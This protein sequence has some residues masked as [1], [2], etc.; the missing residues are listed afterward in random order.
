MP[1]CAGK[2]TYVK[3]L[4]MVYMADTLCRSCQ[5]LLADAIT[6]LTRFKCL[7]FYRLR[8]RS[9]QNSD[10]CQCRARSFASK[11]DVL[12]T[13]IKRQGFVEVSQLVRLPQPPHCFVV[14]ILVLSSPPCHAFSARRASSSS[15]LPEHLP[16]A[17]VLGSSIPTLAFNVQP[18][19]C[20]GDKLLAPC[21]L[22]SFDDHRASSVRGAR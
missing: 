15:P 22:I 5:W 6:W 12:V 10:C 3:L 4:D 9:C 13:F 20:G 1:S 7:P 11:R 14:R 18:K 21:H 19:K 16:N 17:E 2:S 8:C